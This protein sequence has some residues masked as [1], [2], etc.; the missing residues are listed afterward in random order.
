MS[1]LK[2]SVCGGELEV[3]PDLTVGKCKYCDATILIPKEL[4]RKGKLYNRAVFLRQNNE[5]DKAASIYEEILKEDN[6]DADAHWGLV[7]CE[8]GIEYV[9]DP[10]DGKRKPTCHRTQATS[11]LS[12]PDYKA[13]LQFADLEA[14]RV[15]E[16]E[17][18]QIHEIQAK[19]L[20]IATHEPPYDVF[21]SYKESDELGNR[22]KDSVIAQDIYYELAEKRN[23]RVFFARKT[24]EKKLGSEYEPIIYAAL[25]TAKVMVVIGTCPEHFTSVWVKNEWSRFLRM[26][27]HSDKV[28]IPAYQDMSPYEL[29]DELS[30]LQALDMSKIGYLQDLIDG[31]QRIIRIEQSVPIQGIGDIPQRKLE[32]DQPALSVERLI[33]NGDTFLRLKDFNSAEE[34]YR[35]A[36][37]I[38]PEDYRGWWGLIRIFTR[39]FTRIE[40]LDDTRKLSMRQ[41]VSSIHQLAPEHEMEEMD[42]SLQQFCFKLGETQVEDEMASVNK[43]EAD[44]HQKIEVDRNRVAEC[45]NKIRQFERDYREKKTA[46]SAKLSQAQTVQKQKKALKQSYMNASHAGKTRYKLIIALSIAAIIAAIVLKS[47]ENEVLM[48]AAIVLAVLSVSFLVMNGAVRATAVMHAEEANESMMLYE[49]KV[50]K[51][52]KEMASL[53]SDHTQVANDLSKEIEQRKAEINN[54]ECLI[55]DCGQYMERSRVEISGLLG[56]IVYADIGGTPSNRYETLQQLR[57]HIFC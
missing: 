39:D 57:M 51:L 28:L 24:L 53:E 29:P 8:Y 6:E 26:N 13:A 34:A 20:Q 11:I 18:K 37:K 21:I 4:D 40:P 14:S 35:T 30:V 23:Y 5:F 49:A 3:T 52:S 48:Y 44:A 10:K 55:S 56:D 31:I 1:I 33:Q 36:T 16:S 12:D 27:D 22:T 42:S 17:A 54:L 2:C 19:I 50:D 45:E 38:Y 32:N 41:C 9:K 25:S 43:C 46:L 47:A 15:I 7:L